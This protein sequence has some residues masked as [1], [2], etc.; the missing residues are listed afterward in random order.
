M[1]DVTYYVKDGILYKCRENDGATFMRYGPQSEITA[2]CKIEEA[3]ELYPEIHE[4]L[5]R[6]RNAVCQ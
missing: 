2:L 4:R 6:Q 1:A 5:V 3:E